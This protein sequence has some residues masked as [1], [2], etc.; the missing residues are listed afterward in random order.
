MRELEVAGSS[1]AVAQSPEA[2][3][4]T[5]DIKSQIAGPN[6]EQIDELLVLLESYGVHRAS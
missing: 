1:R 4:C 5:L 2:I 6:V 3:G